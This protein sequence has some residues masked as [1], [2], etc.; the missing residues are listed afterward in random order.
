MM[1]QKLFEPEMSSRAV[2]AE[3]MALA[4]VK[5]AAEIG[6]FQGLYSEALCQKIPGLHLLCVDTWKP[7]RNHKNP[8]RMERYYRHAQKRLAPFKTTFMRMTSLEAA[9]LVNDNSLDAVYI[10]AL[11]DYKN[12]LDDLNA[13]VPK[14]RPGGIIA[15]HDW[16]HPGVTAAVVEFTE[17]HGIEQIY[18]TINCDADWYPSFCWVNNGS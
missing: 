5:E 18:T 10:D 13:W 12:V 9:T 2:L 6:V 4:G 7:S 1:T 15:G 11:H 16:S 8:V 14:V 17:I 3:R